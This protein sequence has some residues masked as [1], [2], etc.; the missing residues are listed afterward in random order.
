M[1]KKL[2]IDQNIEP[3]FTDFHNDLFEQENIT[4]EFL[5]ENIQKPL[6]NTLYVTNNIDNITLNCQSVY[7]MS[8]EYDF[9]DSKHALYIRELADIVK[10]YNGD[11]IVNW[12]NELQFLA[13]NI[14]A[15]S[16]NK[17]DIER[18]ERLREISCEMLSYKYDTPIETIKQVFA[19]EIGYQ[20]PKIE[21]RA[22]IIH[23]NKILLVKEQVDNKWALPGG[24]QDVDKTVKENIIKESYEEA[25]AVVEPVKTVALLN[26]NKH[27]NY[28]FPLGM[29][30]I[31]VL[32]RYVSH[33]F[34]IN[35]ETSDVKFFGLDE[36]PELSENRT[37]KKQIEM[38]FDCYNNQDLWEVIFD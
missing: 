28:K 34:L 3:L 20:T 2:Y 12:A 17:F 22:A 18:A 27:H 36:L 11:I 19:S 38:C 30:K 23:D 32:C 6:K 16:N 15:Y 14:L 29:L 25:G 4:F 21:N 9:L 7:L 31:F 1:Y 37:T 10:I 13:Q 33:N 8:N 24:Y 26:Y 35:T 5:A